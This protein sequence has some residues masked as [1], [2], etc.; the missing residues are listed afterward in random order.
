MLTNF[1]QKNAPKFECELCDFK[2]SKKSNFN[3]HLR[4]LKH[5]QLQMPDSF[6][7][8]NAEKI[9]P[10]D[11]GKEYKHRQSLS[12]HKKTCKKGQPGTDTTTNINGNNETVNDVVIKLIN[13]NKELQ[14]TLIDQNKMIME[15]AQKA[16]N[17]NNISSRFFFIGFKNQ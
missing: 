12:V 9:F 13:Q 10:C 3:E 6:L 15:L 2:C 7:P 14:Q 16:G 8:K 5:K 1:Q 4:T 17:N 11:C